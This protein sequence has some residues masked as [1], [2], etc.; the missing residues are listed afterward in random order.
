MGEPRTVVITGA[1]RGLGFASAVRLY[2]EGWR[3]VAAMRTP[4]RAMPQLRQATGACDDDER[5]IGV[6]LDLTD[7]ASVSAAAKATEEAVGAPY[8]IVHNAGISAA[9][10]VEETDMALWQKMFATHVMG[11]VALTQALLPSMRAA[12]EGRIV[13][14]ASTAGVRGQPGTAPYSAAKGAL[15][16]W[17]ESMAVEIAPF[18]LGVTILVTGTY[19]TDIITDAGTT[20]DRNFDGPYARLHN[21]MNTRGRFAIRFARAPERFADGLLKALDD[22]GPFRR[23]GVGPDASMLLVS[24]RML[25]AIGMHHMSR[26]VLGIPKQGSMRGGAWPLTVG[27]RAMVVLARVLPEPVLTGL[28]SLAA[29]R[30]KENEGD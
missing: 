30:R 20:D 19:D 24:N 16:R 13:L 2:R 28:A 15:E 8:A 22:R 4:D 23:R 6:Q 18:G 29:K 11:P 17:G 26:I 1:S 27:Q 10:M 25:P 5:L 12:G 14:V 7:G 3:V 9:G 21:T